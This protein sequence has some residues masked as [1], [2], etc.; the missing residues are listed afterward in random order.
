MNTDGAPEVLVSQL[1]ILQV[2]IDGTVNDCLL[3]GTDGKRS[4]QNF[5][6]SALSSR[7]NGFRFEYVLCTVYFSTSQQL[8]LQVHPTRRSRTQRPDI[9]RQTSR[10]LRRRSSIALRQLKY[11]VL[12]R[13]RLMPQTMLHIQ[14]H[15]HTEMPAQMRQDRQPIR[16]HGSG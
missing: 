16:R 9:L 4:L 12:N 7:V 11:R 8:H 1:I 13:M 6:Y 5:V 10:H 3:V 14:N 2:D 15:L